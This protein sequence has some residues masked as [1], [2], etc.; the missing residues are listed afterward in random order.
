ME[1]HPLLLVLP[2]QVSLGLLGEEARMLGVEV[3][4]GAGCRL[5]GHGAD[6]ALVENLAVRRLDVGL[7]GV[8]TPKHHCAARTPWGGSG[9]HYGEVGVSPYPLP[10]PFILKDWVDSK[11]EISGGGA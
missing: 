11:K 6:G 9:R 8:H 1:P 7:D 10:H 2:P 3:G 5:E 4:M